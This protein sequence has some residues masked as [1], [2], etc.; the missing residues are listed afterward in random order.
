MRRPGTL[1]VALALLLVASAAGFAVAARVERRREAS[2]TAGLDL[3]EGSAAREAAERGN[4]ATSTTPVTTAIPPTTSPIVSATTTSTNPRSAPEGSA[5]R[6]AAERAHDSTTASPTTTSSV[7]T[8]LATTVPTTTVKTPPVHVRAPKI[9]EE[10]FGIRTESGAATAAAVAV[11]LGAAFVALAGRR[12]TLL[13]IAGLAL[14]FV[15]LDTREALH[16]HDEG[17]TELV[18]AALALVHLAAAAIG[19]LA[20]RQIASASAR[21]ES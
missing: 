19:L 11:L 16:Q 17:R 8:T 6:E 3:P 2:A 12:W 10:L 14:L 15:L 9:G 7:T 13:G 21:F 1:R 18:A 4:T 20:Y 5:A